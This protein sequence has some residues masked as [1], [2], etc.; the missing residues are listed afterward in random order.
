VQTPPPIFGFFHGQESHSF[1]A[2]ITVKSSVLVYYIFPILALVLNGAMKLY[3]KK[4]NLQL[5]N[6]QPIFIMFGNKTETVLKQV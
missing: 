3:S 5:E 1:Y 2:E 6:S 4:L